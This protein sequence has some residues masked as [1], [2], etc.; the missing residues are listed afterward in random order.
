[1]GKMAVDTSIV[2]SQIGK[3]HDNAR[4]FSFL[5]DFFAKENH[6]GLI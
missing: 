2:V 5:R 1:M 4:S 6:I 3:K